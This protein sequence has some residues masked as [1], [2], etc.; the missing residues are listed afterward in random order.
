MS[1]QRDTPRR[2]SCVNRMVSGMEIAQRDIVAMVRGAAGGE[3][4]DRHPTQALNINVS[5][6]WMRLEMSYKSDNA[7]QGHLTL[8][9]W[10]KWS[11]RGHRVVV[12]SHS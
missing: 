3:I 8:F 10:R 2:T 1:A 9:E 7:R 4:R 6:R 12:F 5:E 11:R